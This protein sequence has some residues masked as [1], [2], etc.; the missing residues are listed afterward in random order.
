MI[1]SGCKPG[2]GA[3][4]SFLLS[5]SNSGLKTNYLVARGAA[6]TKANSPITSSAH[7]PVA[8]RDDLPNDRMQGI[9]SGAATGQSES[10]P[11]STHNAASFAMY[12]RHVLSRGKDPAV[13]R[14]PQVA[15]ARRS[16][17]LPVRMGGRHG[18]RCRSR[19]A[20]SRTRTRRFN[21]TRGLDTFAV[22]AASGAL[23]AHLHL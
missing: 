13:E 9:G 19:P 18:G 22:I 8:P 20:W 14:C 7:F 21:M 12:F 17:L 3:I 2:E 1:S 11:R 6:P 15:G 4:Q 5:P 10:F 23:Q 16:S